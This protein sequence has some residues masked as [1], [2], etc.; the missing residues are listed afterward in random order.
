MEIQNEYE[1]PKP[2]GR[3]ARLMQMVD[4]SKKI[5][6]SSI[7]EARRAVLNFFIYVIFL[8]L[9]SV[10]TQ[11]TNNVPM[12]YLNDAMHRQVI[13]RRV[14]MEPGLISKYTDIDS[15]DRYWD[16]VLYTFL[17]L[18]SSGDFKSTDKES[19]W[20]FTNE[21]NQFNGIYGDIYNR[22]ILHGNVLLGPPRFRQI[23]VERGHCKKCAP[24][25]KHMD[26]CY[27][28]YTWSNERR[29][30][31]RGTK[32]V[33]MWA[34][35]AL[36]IIGEIEVYLG[37][38]YIK[39]LSYDNEFNFRLVK[40]LR[41]TKWIGRSTRIVLIELSLFH[42][43]TRLFE[44]VKL[45]VERPA[46]GGLVPSYSLRSLRQETFFTDSNWAI[47][48][49]VC[50]YYLMVVLFTFREIRIIKK[51]GFC[52][53]IRNTINLADFTCYVCSYIILLIHVERFFYL[54]S[55]MNIIKTS[56]RYINLDWASI[57]AVI[58]NNIAA[59]TIFLAWIRI[60]SFL[61]F[62]RTLVIF[63]NVVRESTSE[64]VGFLLMFIAV[65]M[66]YAECGM[67][68][69]GHNDKQ[70]YNLES[71]LLTMVSLV[72]GE[73]RFDS[74]KVKET[75]TR[76]YFMSFVIIV[77]ALLLFAFLAIIN[78]T[79]DEIQASMKTRAFKL[80]LVI[81]LFFRSLY[82]LIYYIF[83]GKRKKR[84]KHDKDMKSELATD[85]RIDPQEAAQ[86]AAM[87][88]HLLQNP[89][90]LTQTEYLPRRIE[91][92]A[93]RVKALEEVTGPVL[94]RLIGYYNTFRREQDQE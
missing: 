49:V 3:W 89:V 23:M 44:S 28:P 72:V 81:R 14:P 91:C 16:F 62:N 59:I 92:A 32:W 21:T 39:S 36:P 1:P 73:F 80:G 60:L 22:V 50:S 93:K 5:R 56:D 46:T 29:S 9:A 77:Y 15:L 19:I 31:Y 25:T 27:A 65:G 20:E 2:K 79:Y 40:H 61:V 63:V 74:F 70:F 48:I 88:R 35:G 13:G 24:F 34:D 8:A 41:D 84:V 45:K 10:V 33:G 26:T 58:Y 64:M 57:V 37:A 86:R 17:P 67:T 18:L 71:S 30:D 7:R 43:N 53:Y 85:Q 54:S 4:R 82:D 94:K 75:K 38:G 6:Y 78:C 76:I 11:T 55:I 90:T 87:R 68:F 66:A 69:F 42:V 83:C 47:Q 51:T 52:K 12:Y